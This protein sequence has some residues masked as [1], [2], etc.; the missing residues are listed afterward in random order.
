VHARHAARI[1]RADVSCPPPSL[2]LSPRRAAATLAQ[3]GE[4][5][6]C[7]LRLCTEWWPARAIVARALDESEAAAAQLSGSE[8]SARRQLLLLDGGGCPWQ[9]HLLALEAERGVQPAACIK[10]VLYAD[11]RAQWR[12]QAVP[13]EEGSFSSKLPLPEP[14]RGLRDGSLSDAAAIPGCVFVHAAG[15]IGGHETKEGAMQLA[16]KALT[17]LGAC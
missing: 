8:R 2:P 13:Q 7:V 17:L 3:A 10:Y 6:S 9:A 11:A 14:W 12:V 4:L 1:A 5:V 15:F 16:S